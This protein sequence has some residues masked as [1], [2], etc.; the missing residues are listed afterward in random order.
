MERH[1][2]REGGFNSWCLLLWSIITA[3]VCLTLI[4]EVTHF[5]G[6]D[7]CFNDFRRCG[8]SRFSRFCQYLPAP[9]LP[10]RYPVD[11]P[12]FQ[13]GH[14]PTSPQVDEFGSGNGTKAF[15]GVGDGELDCE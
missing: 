2:S 10:W 7:M 3:I 15:S 4:S 1:G 5:I 13:P 6:A 8:F 11:D 9:S 14:A 12:P